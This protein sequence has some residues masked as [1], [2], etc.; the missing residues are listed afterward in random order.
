MPLPTPN[1]DESQ[2]DFM[3][4]C[5]PVIADDTTYE[6]QEQRVAVCLSQFR[7]SAKSVKVL[8]AKRGTIG[9]WGIPFGGPIKVKENADGADLDGEWFASDTNFC[10]DWNP[11]ENRPVLYE[12]GID[13]DLALDVVGRQTSKFVDDK[14]G[15]WTEVQLNMAHRYADAILDLAKKGVLGFSSGALGGYVRR[16]S[17]GKLTQWPWIELS[18]TPRPANPYALIPE[19]AVKHFAGTGIEVPEAL[20]K[21]MA[22][23]GEQKKLTLPDG[24]SMDDMRMK[25]EYAIREVR[26]GLG[27]DDDWL[28]VQDIRDDQVVVSAEENGCWQYTFKLLPTGDVEITGDPQQVMLESSYVPAKALTDLTAK[29]EEEGWTKAGRVMSARNMGQLHQ[30][31]QAM[32]DLHGNTCDMGTDCPVTETA[33]SKTKQEDPPPYPDL[34]TPEKKSQRAEID[35]FLASIKL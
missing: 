12:H 20:A 18:L 11:N 33:K 31:V 25:L 28:W 27:I 6:S 32:N 8:D 5:M 34:D 19:D 29:L 7:E 3:A 2:D 26:K 14:L 30:S 24:M 1:T 23:G 10:F 21:A 16:E 15:V 35:A 4:R 13:K 17:T 9:G 22:D